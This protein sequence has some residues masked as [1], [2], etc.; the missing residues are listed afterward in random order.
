MQFRTAQTVVRNRYK[1]GSFNIRGKC[2]D[3]RNL[4]EKR[5]LLACTMVADSDPASDLLLTSYAI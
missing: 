1:G 2:V 5:E 3:L 4:D